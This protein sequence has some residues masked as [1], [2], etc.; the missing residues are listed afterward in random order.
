MARMAITQR[1]GNKAATGMTGI[2][3]QIDIHHEQWKSLEGRES[4]P[5]VRITHCRMKTVMLSDTSSLV[6]RAT[7]RA[8]TTRLVISMSY[9]V[10]AP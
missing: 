1:L 8:A 2:A 4:G 6:R 3:I 7:A 10:R 9:S 5:Q